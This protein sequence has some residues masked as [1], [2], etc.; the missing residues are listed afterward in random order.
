MGGTNPPNGRWRGW[1]QAA[2][3]G[4]LQPR[5]IEMAIWARA[6]V[7]HLAAAVALV[8]GS[9]AGL[10]T[11]TASPAAAAN[12]PIA[13]GCAA[14]PAADLVNAVTAA[15]TNAGADTIT[16]TAGCTYTFAV[17]DN[18]WYGPNALPAIAS[19]ITI[20]GNGATIAR[21]PSTPNFRLFFVGAAHT[22]PYTN[23]YVTPG[24]GRLVLREVTLSNGLARGGDSN[25][26]GG[27]AGMGG[28]IFSQGVVLIERS[29]LTANR[30]AGGSAGNVAVGD[31]GGGMG[32]PSSG[33]YGGGFGTP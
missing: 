17:A 14:T 28:A 1:S 9:L 29:T 3:V 27:G 18:N 21:A 13:I 20:E 2:T 11:A 15:N 23:N 8:G 19:D 32:T 24:A 5:G 7:T 12:A 22:S 33:S 16:L 31:G 30:A 4:G 10:L 25:T 26:G 6:R